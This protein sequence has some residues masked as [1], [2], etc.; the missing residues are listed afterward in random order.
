MGQ[1]FGNFVFSDQESWKYLS[2][3]NH[4]S[5]IDKSSLQKDKGEGTWTETLKSATRY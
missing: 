2:E 1:E 5:E 4:N 3:E